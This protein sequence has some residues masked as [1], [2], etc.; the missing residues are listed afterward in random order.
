MNKTDILKLTADT[1]RVIAADA[2]QKAN[3]GHP[4]MP[5]G[6]ADCAAVLWTKFLNFNPEDPDWINRDRFILSA[7]HGSML[8]Y[9]MLYLSGYD[10]KLDDLRNF[11]QWG[12][13]TP[14]HPEYGCL[15]GIETTTGPLGQGFANGV[16]MAIAA[17]MT[18]ARFNKVRRQLFGNHHIYG[19]VSDG[20]LMEGVASEAASLA[21][22][23]Q[24]GNLIY[25]YD[26][27]K[28]TIEGESNLTFTED[29]A[30]RFKSYGWHITKIDG[31][32]LDQIEH[33]LNEADQEEIRP[34]L[35]I[36]KTHI[37]F[38]SPNKQ[39]SAGAHGAPLGQEELTATKQALGFDPDQYFF[40]PEDVKK[41]FADRRIELKTKYESWM[42]VYRLWQ[43]ENPDLESKREAMYEKHLPDDLEDQLLKSLNDKETA[44][45]NYSGQIM[46]KIAHILPG[47]VG[48]SAD[49]EPSTKTCLKAFPSVQKNHFEGRNFH[50][51]IR[52][53]AMASINNG[54]ALYGGFIPFGS[55]FL[56]FSDYMRP[57]L[58][59]AAIM[60]LHHINVFT[61][62]SIYVGEDGPTHQPVEHVNALRMIPGMTV[63][64][65]AD[66]L[67]TALCWAVALR[68]KDGPSCLI[69]TRQTVRHISRPAHF[70]A[71]M[72][73]RGA[74]VIASETNGPAELAIL[75]SGSEVYNSIEAKK[76]LETNGYAVR[77]VSIPS[78]ELFDQQP[79]TYK[80]EVLP[81]SLN[82]LAVVEAGT[83]FGWEPYLGLPLKKIT[84]D[85]F[86]ASAPYT[87][88]EEKFGFTAG[89]IAEEI[90]N[91]LD[92]LN[93]R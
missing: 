9:T 27:N 14:G 72:V 85:R 41:I 18:A 59:L 83:G 45:R 66:A 43:R 12:S 30:M 22:H 6:M 68:R 58:R 36:A 69:L 15:P 19:I 88:L 63:L 51:G 49:L 37:G 92:S 47:F 2:V 64:R 50:F 32:D 75:A 56:V 20:D 86:G 11:R 55:T 82:A 7:G 26:D 13:R 46:Q 61:H 48:G 8:L 34:T 53:H 62:D 3:S 31:H 21:G 24:L 16:G 91:Y 87:V 71:S 60:K 77:V 10:V 35:I 25:F 40:V 84:I 17:K 42:E 80:R 29:V 57:A 79:D 81:E 28:I 23:L 33:A 76:L 78:K 73:E 65:P 67:E 1:I 52:E 44:T 90:S 93:T 39:D 89:Q 54:I 5:M 4:G 70:E 38:G 74:Y